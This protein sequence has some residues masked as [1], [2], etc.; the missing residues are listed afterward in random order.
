MDE[1]LDY[2]GFAMFRSSADRT[3]RDAVML[4]Q[5]CSDCAHHVGYQ[6]HVFFAISV[7]F[8]PKRVDQNGCLHWRIYNHDFLC[9]HRDR[10]TGSSHA[11]S[12]NTV[13]GKRPSESTRQIRCFVCTSC[14]CWTWDRRLYFDFTSRRSIAVAYSN[15]PKDSS[16]PRLHHWNTVCNSFRLCF[17]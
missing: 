9:K 6:T 2:C 5:H 16:L 1:R 14:C 10:A 3:N 4:H 13:D 11:K 15:S 8:P 12:W 17:V 7:Y